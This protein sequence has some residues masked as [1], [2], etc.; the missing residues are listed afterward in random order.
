VTQVRVRSENGYTLTYD[1]G[2]VENVHVSALN[3]TMEIPSGYAMRREPTGFMS[4]DLH[5]DFKYGKQASWVKDE[6]LADTSDVAL[7]AI[8]D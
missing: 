7:G 8:D 3:H 1:T 5:I 4:M 6:E 2:D